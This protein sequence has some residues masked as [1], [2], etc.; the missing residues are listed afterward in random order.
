MTT[1]AK[2]AIIHLIIIGEGRLARPKHGKGEEL[3]R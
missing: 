2:Y 3:W 1:A